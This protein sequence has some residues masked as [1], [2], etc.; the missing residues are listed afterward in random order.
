MARMHEPSFAEVIQKTFELYKNN[1]RLLFGV[2]IV[3]AIVEQLCQFFMLKLGL[4]EMMR[5]TSQEGFNA[6]QVHFGTGR[7]FSVAGLSMLSGIVM[8]TANAFYQQVVDGSWQ[9]ETPGPG[10]ALVAVLRVLPVLV[11]TS[12]IVKF[13]SGLFMM[14][15]LF[16]VGFLIGAL[17]LVYM[18]V[19]LF[20]K[21][22]VFQSLKQTVALTRLSYLRCVGIYIIVFALLSIPAVTGMLFNGQGPRFGLEQWLA[23]VISGFVYPWASTLILAQY[24]ALKA[25]QS[26][27][28]GDVTEE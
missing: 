17:F 28:Q 4:Q 10:E 13:L 7:M 26:N 18:P 5:L 16:F 9:G 12:I 6:I 27:L 1:L 20:E 8:L 15:I 14:S 23:I 11:I 2:A 19:V 21:Q 24:Y 22:G 3:A 25:R